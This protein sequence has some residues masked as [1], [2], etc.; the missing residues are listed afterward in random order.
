[1]KLPDKDAS[2]RPCEDTPPGFRLHNRDSRTAGVRDQLEIRPSKR[3]QHA[4]ITPRMAIILWIPQEQLK[5]LVG[6]AR[7]LAS[8]VTT[9][10][11]HI[12]TRG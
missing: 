2:P 7:V 3:E 4:A 1:M 12:A 9:S 10:T 11:I 5:L 8:V 6:H